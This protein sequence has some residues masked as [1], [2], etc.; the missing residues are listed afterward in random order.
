MTYSRGLLLFW[1][2]ILSPVAIFGQTATGATNID[3]SPG[4]ISILR[5]PASN[6][7]KYELIADAV[8]HIQHK[9]PNNLT[10]EL[11]DRNHNLVTTQLIRTTLS[12]KA[13]G[14]T[15][16]YTG[17]LL[18]QSRSLV[19]IKISDGQISGMIS[20]VRG[21]YYL[22]T[23]IKGRIIVVGTE[24][25]KT[26]HQWTCHTSP[27]DLNK[28]KSGQTAFK[29]TNTDTLNIYFVCDYELYELFGFSHTALTSYVYEMFHQVQ[30]IY[31][32]EQ[33]P[34]RI[35]GIDIWEVPD[36]YSDVTT[37]DALLSFRDHLG[38][39]YPGH[40]A[41][42]LSGSSALSGG[43]AFINGLCDRSKSFGY[44]NIDGAVSSGGQYSW[45]V[46]VVAHELGHNIGS[47]HTH[48][49]AWGPDGTDAIDSC[50]EPDPSCANA[51]IPSAGGTIMSYC[52]S[53]NAGVNFSLGFGQEP[54]DL[55]RS[56]LI[57]CNP[58]SGESCA[59]AIALTEDGS[60]NSGA[61]VSGSGAH[62]TQSTHARWFRYDAI[63][64]G[65]LT[66]SSCNQGVDTRLFIYDGSCDLLNQLASSDDDCLS[67]SGFNYASTI[68]DLYIEG[69]TS[70]FI[71]WDDRW[72]NDG[73]SFSITF[74]VE[75][76][77]S[78][79]IQDG[80]ESGV[81][82]G[83]GCTPCMIACEDDDPL[84]STVVDSTTYITSSAITYSGAVT[85]GALLEISS[86]IDITV[87]SGFEVKTGSSLEVSIQEC[88]DE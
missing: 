83:G 3:R 63:S 25:H 47:P 69:G 79:G 20:D 60:Y 8:N 71:E 73:F 62:H 15:I 77:C 43:K 64:H 48:D 56:K 11:V 9:H 81:D 57:E 54:G 34:I 2:I 36:P 35:E 88:I 78:N 74:D 33:I 7:S 84:P 75:D 55:L 24:H 72:S 5:S 38:E 76:I 51:P 29:S 18:D 44:S 80:D 21:N 37:G 14:Q 32:S 58:G 26:N 82:C 39:D 65:W 49:C 40:F 28:R 22:H 31:A 53:T 70:V 10:T 16:Y 23:S 66:V 17:Y 67:G 85:L 19:T 86:G 27:D 68:T 12:N 45:D 4:Y 42:L 6:D 46:H 1:M 59:E 41:H 50:G 61:L 87:H 52:H 30:A 13:V